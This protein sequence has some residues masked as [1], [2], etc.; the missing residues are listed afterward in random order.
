MAEPRV[1]ATG[2][3]APATR[4]RLRLRLRYPDGPHNAATLLIDARSGALSIV[5]KQN[6]DRS[7]VYVARPQPEGD[8]HAAARHT[9]EAGRRRTG[10][11]AG[12]SA[13]TAA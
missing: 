10:H 6:D 11:G 12:T 13:P 9:A 2:T 7:G 1:P 4:L 3:T 5:T 8:D